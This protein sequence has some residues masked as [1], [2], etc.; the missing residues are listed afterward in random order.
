MSIS[1][2]W[3]AFP[4][5]GIILNC[6]INTHHRS[7]LL[8][9]TYDINVVKSGKRT[10]SCCFSKLSSEIWSYFNMASVKVSS[11]GGITPFRDF[12]GFQ[13]LLITTLS[14]FQR[15]S[16]FWIWHLIFFGPLYSLYFNALTRVLST[17]SALWKEK[18]L[19]ARLKFSVCDIRAGLN[20]GHVPVS[21]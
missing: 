15:R 18:C 2:P 9:A 13:F 17:L 7:L 20:G 5:S 21:E 11:I 10:R 12:S 14:A 3:D 8:N 16:L 19:H 1:Q 6:N 4:T